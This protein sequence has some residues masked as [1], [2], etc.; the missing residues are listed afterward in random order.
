MVAALGGDI[1]VHSE[2]GR[3]ATFRVTLP[4]QS[5]P[6]PPE[7]RAAPPAPVASGRRPRLLL[8]DDE[9]HLGVTLSVGLRDQADVVSVRSGRE[10]V[11][12][13]LA[14]DGFDLVLCD[15]MMP[16]LTGMD[17]FEQVEKERPSLRGRFVFMTGGAVTERARKFLE[18]IPS[19]RLDKPF[20]LE[21]VEAL[22]RR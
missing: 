21:Q 16:D 19:Q 9:A 4:M 13:L 1:Q 7:R 20:R 2:P 8:V 14:D 3:G 6:P 11:R 17:V 5:K 15:L 10:A 22:L 18:Q 12:A